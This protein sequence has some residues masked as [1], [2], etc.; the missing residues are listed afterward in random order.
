MLSLCVHSRL[1]S[2]PSATVESELGRG[3]SG[4]RDGMSVPEEDDSKSDT[5][6]NLFKHS[7]VPPPPLSPSPLPRA[8][9]M[10]LRRTVGWLSIRNRGE[11]L[12]RPDAL[13][14]PSLAR[15]MQEVKVRIP[16]R[17]SV[18]PPLSRYGAGRPIDARIAVRKDGESARR[19]GAKRTGGRGASSL[20]PLRTHAGR[21]QLLWWAAA[22]K[23]QAVR[24]VSERASERASSPAGDGVRSEQCSLYRDLIT[25]AH[26]VWHQGTNI[27]N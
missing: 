2:R 12:H 8:A 23:R 7:P 11:A 9:G 25:F 16:G 17:P 5:T 24:R 27:Q 14:P 13:P 15:S 3:R 18:R 4:R 20:S 19:G 6:Q 1:G 21:P 26:P 22:G 10:F